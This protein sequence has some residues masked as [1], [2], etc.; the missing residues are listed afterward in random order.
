MPSLHGLPASGVWGKC[1]VAKPSSKLRRPVTPSAYRPGADAQIDRAI[2]L[3]PALEAFL[4]Q[5]KD[6]HTSLEDGFARL[7]EILSTA[8]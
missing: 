2:Q 1:S 6:E 4:S 8:R 3:N 5:D 7:Q